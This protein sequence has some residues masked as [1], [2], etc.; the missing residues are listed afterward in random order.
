[1][2]FIHKY[3]RVSCGL[4]TMPDVGETTCNKIDLKFAPLKLRDWNK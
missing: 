4:D 3:L 1:M 2:S